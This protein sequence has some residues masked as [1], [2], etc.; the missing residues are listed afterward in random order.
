MNLLKEQQKKIAQPSRNIYMECLRR[1][2]LAVTTFKQL[3]EL[4]ER[5]LQSCRNEKSTKDSDEVA[6]LK[7]Q[8][9]ESNDFAKSLEPWK[10]KAEN[11]ERMCQRL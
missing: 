10:T 8:L 5:N 11:H 6:N 7:K 3:I 1:R 2:N 4:A 9:R